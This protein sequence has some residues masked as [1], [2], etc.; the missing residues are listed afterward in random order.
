ML[1]LQFLIPMTRTLDSV[2]DWNICHSTHGTS[3][4]DEVGNLCTSRPTQV[5]QTLLT[6]HTLDPL[7]MLFQSALAIYSLLNIMKSV[8]VSQN[9]FL[10]SPRVYTGTMNKRLFSWHSFI[11]FSISATLWLLKYLVACCSYAW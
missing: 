10:G 1:L 7:Y 5:L 3:S 8:A 2:T 9:K 6:M 11:S 4:Q